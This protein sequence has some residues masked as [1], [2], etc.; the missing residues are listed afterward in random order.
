MYCLVNY[1][2]I[3]WYILIST[4]THF[5]FYT[6]SNEYLKIKTFPLATFPNTSVPVLKIY[7]LINH[8]KIYIKKSHHSPNKI[9]MINWMSQTRIQLGIFTQ[10][11]TYLFLR[12]L[13]YNLQVSTYRSMFL[14][15][16]Y[17]KSVL[18]EQLF[19]LCPWFL[20]CIHKISEHSTY[21]ILYQKRNALIIYVKHICKQLKFK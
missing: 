11:V 8:T 12:Y 4:I 2:S 16:F 1:S 15:K 6:I 13:F 5:L 3:S 18:T 10:K 19:I 14:S 7:A 20:R 17:C 21:Y 9:L